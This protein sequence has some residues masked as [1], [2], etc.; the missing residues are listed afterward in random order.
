MAG[1]QG[2]NGRDKL[3]ELAWDQITQGFQGYGREFL[4]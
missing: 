3:G 2:V 1:A 4:V